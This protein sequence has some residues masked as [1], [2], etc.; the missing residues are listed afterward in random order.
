MKN[1]VSI[2]LAAGAS[3]R[4]KSKTSKLLHPVLGRSLIQW[5][6]L[7]ARMMSNKVVVVLGHQKDALEEEIN[8]LGFPESEIQFAVQVQQKGTAD[9]VQVA[10]ESISSESE[11]SNVFIMGGDSVLLKEETVKKFKEHHEKTGE[12]LSV[13]TTC[14][15]DPAAY[16]RIV[17]G[18]TGLVQKI[19]E[20]KDASEKEKNI[21]EINSG[22]Y[23]VK[24][25][26]LRS[27]LKD[28]SDKNKSSEF[29]LTDLVEIAHSK[30]SKI[31]A[32]EISPEE[33][34]GVN[35]QADLADTTAVLQERVN[36]KW[37]LEGVCMVDPSSVWL[38]ADVELSR[39]VRLE[40]GV[41][42]KGH[43][44][45][46][47]GSTIGSYSVIENSEIGKQTRIQP[48]CHIFE[49]KVKD[50]CTIGPYARLRP[51]AKLENE[52]HVGNFVEI[53]KGHLR[54]GAKANHL[55]YLGDC[56]VGSKANVGA[57]TITCN[58]D[59]VLKHFTKIGD[60]AF[61]GSNASLVAPV[62]IGK[63]SIVGAGSVIT[64][65]VSDNS[66]GVER[67][68]QREVKEGA[69]RFRDKRKKN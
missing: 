53:K 68:D 62:E 37:L 18:E 60:E 24:L 43:S 9:A 2:I 35:T 51:G 59:G 7:Q 56:E 52:V 63:G 41:Q 11:D 32:E 44:K 15:E 33:S 28:I 66:I 46:G 4:M 25:A 67:S 6:V 13:M 16:G 34:W 22:F 20:L 30:D 12:I 48:M 5:A 19:V 10:L 55:S 3:T 40:P 17:R 45:I 61:I 31:H 57:G 39:D 8:A 1:T 38:D 26:L 47:E 23:L 21:H 27:L 54:D 58:Y 64:K 49:A 65:N 36:M 14:L 29:Y 50:D 69:K 42:I